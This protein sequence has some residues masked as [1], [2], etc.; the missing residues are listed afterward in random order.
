MKLKLLLCTVSIVIFVYSC[1][2]NDLEEPLNTAVSALSMPNDCTESISYNAKIV[3]FAKF[4]VPPEDLTAGERTLTLPKVDQRIYYICKRSDG[5]VY[6]EILANWESE[7]ES[8]FPIRTLGAPKKTKWRSTNDNGL[9]TVYDAENAVIESYTADEAFDENA[10]IF[11]KYQSSLM[12]EESYELFVESLSNEME[13]ESISN[14]LFAV[15][16]V[17][18]NGLRKTYFDKRYQREVA[19]EN[20]TP[21][22]QL[23]NRTSFLY[24]ENNG[25][26]ILENEI[27]E[28]F[29]KSI[30]SDLI[31]TMVKLTSYTYN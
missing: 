30:D 22:R 5:R 1:S 20:Y 10:D 8:D 9:I 28:T 17:S 11:L 13:V 7:V 12:S 29:K 2:N 19:I 27:F 4:D 6:T 23:L 14:D 21:E 15:V 16:S 24:G 3:S 31:M 26:V 18:S 25:Q